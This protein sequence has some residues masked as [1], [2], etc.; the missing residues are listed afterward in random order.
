M[1]G[2]HPQCLRHARVVCKQNR[3]SSDASRGIADG[4]RQCAIA[5]AASEIKQQTGQYGPIAECLKPER[6]RHEC[7][8]APEQKGDKNDRLSVSVMGRASR[9]DR[10][11][12][13]CEGLK[14]GP[15]QQR[16]PVSE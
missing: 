12:G 8:I 5:V 3:L 15:R 10:L 11:P 16:W 7:E 13:D 6:N 14:P 9:H 1:K 2:G 4:A